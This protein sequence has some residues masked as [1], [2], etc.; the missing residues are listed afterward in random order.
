L[1][2]GPS[3]NPATSSAISDRSSRLRAGARVLDRYRRMALGL[4]INASCMLWRDILISYVGTN[5]RFSW[6][7]WHFALNF[8]SAELPYLAGRGCVSSSAG[9]GNLPAPSPGNRVRA[10]LRAAFRLEARW[11]SCRPLPSISTGPPCK[12]FFRFVANAYM[13]AVEG[14]DRPARSCISWACCFGERLSGGRL[15]IYSL[16]PRDKCRDS[17]M[18]FV[19]AG[20][21]RMNS[22]SHPGENSIIRRPTSARS[23]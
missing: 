9:C 5:S 7:F 17:V 2:S 21:H 15:R 14:V 19:G 3:Y 23:C 18:G 22:S 6:R 10:D 16:L 13:K 1:M 4:A 12:P 8:L 11:Q 20:G